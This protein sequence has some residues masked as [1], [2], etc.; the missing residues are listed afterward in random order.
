M[1]CP[2][3]FLRWLGVMSF[4]GSGAGRL[5]G[6][7]ASTQVLVGFCY[8]GELSAGGRRHWSSVGALGCF[9]QPW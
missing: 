4:P 1:M 9:H 6:T 7:R 8:P 2:R 3:H 5:I